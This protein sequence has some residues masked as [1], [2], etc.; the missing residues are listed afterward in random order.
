MFRLLKFIFTILCV[1]TCTIAFAQVNP[2]A[3]NERLKNIELR[4][5]L[6]Q[7]SVLNSIEFR[8][9]GPS[10]MSG[11]VVDLDVNP[12][13]P[14]EFYVAYATGGLWHTTTNGQSFL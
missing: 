1:I 6:E 4:K 8:N 5:V 3:A 9:I 12:K 10:I 7:R 2:T 14:T 13:D 11:R